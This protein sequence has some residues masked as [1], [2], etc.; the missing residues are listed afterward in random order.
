MQ[1]LLDT[2]VVSQPMRLRAPEVLL[3]RLARIE[4]VSALTT[5]SISEVRFGVLR[6]PI[7][8][9]RARYQSYLE[10]LLASKMPIFPFDLAA[11]EWH[12]SERA[13]LES[14]GLT[15]PFADGQIAAVAATRG[16]TLVTLNLRD[17]E[18]FDGLAIESWD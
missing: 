17:F 5:V 12:A 16:L 7:G 2:S 3:G 13:R 4:A 15:P 14:M 11:A 18:R 10:G 6:L 9:R 8:Q 1:Y